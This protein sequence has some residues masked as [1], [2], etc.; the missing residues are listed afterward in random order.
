MKFLNKKF[1]DLEWY[2]SSIYLCLKHNMR[3]RENKISQVFH[4]AWILI[5]LVYIFWLLHPKLLHQQ[6]KFLYYHFILHCSIRIELNF[7][8]NTSIFG[9]WTL[10]IFAVRELIFF[11][12]FSTS[13]PMC[14]NSPTLSYI[15]KKKK[16]VKS[17]LNWLYILNL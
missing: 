7:F 10:G 15:I 8:S 17:K 2:V 4:L 16:R 1:P 13:E 14:K 3:L 12:K 11:L 9:S 5:L 6:P